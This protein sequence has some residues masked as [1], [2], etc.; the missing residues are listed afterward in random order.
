MLRRPRR[1][2]CSRTGWRHICSAAATK[3]FDFQ[4][5]SPF[6]VIISHPRTVVLAI[7]FY[8]LGHFK[9]VYDDDDDDDDDDT[10]RRYDDLSVMLCQ[11][12]LW[13]LIQDHEP[14]LY[15]NSCA[16]HK[17]SGYAGL[18]LHGNYRAV[19]VD[20]G[21]WDCGIVP[22]CD[23]QRWTLH[24]QTAT[25]RQWRGG[26][27]GHCSCR[28]SH[29]ALYRQWIEHALSWSGCS[30]RLDIDVPASYRPCPT[31]FVRTQLATSSIARLERRYPLHNIV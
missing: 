2:R 23:R 3:L 27:L 4:L 12:I 16:C 10:L 19:A 6:L 28:L 26:R 29:P 9:N 18:Q 25:H 20:A 1:C 11:V 30:D 24:V 13:S 8:C 14:W 17:L 22:G 15:A 21:A 7:V 31:S 5:H